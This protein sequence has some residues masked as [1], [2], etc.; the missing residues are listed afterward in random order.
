MTD[1]SDLSHLP[2]YR[3]PR[4]SVFSARKIA[5]M[6]SV[7]AGLGASVYGFS[8]STSPGDLFSSPAHAQVNQEVRKVER[9]IG[10][11]DIVERVKPSVISVKV[12][13][14][15]KT[16]SNDDGDDSSSPFQPGS[17]M[18]RFFRRFG[19]P[20]GFPGLKGGRGRVVQGQ[21]SGFFISPDG[22]AV[23][24]NH[25]VDGADKVEVTTDDGK[26]YT[27]KVIGTDQR[28]DLALI[29]VEGSSNFP[30]AK[31]ADGKPRI[32]DWVLAVGNPFGLGGTV[33]AGIVSASGRDIGNG[34]YDDFIQI[35]APV[36]KG[37]SGGPAFNTEGEVMGVNTAIYSPSGGSVGIAF[38]IP[39]NTVKSV[40]AQ[41]KDK[42]SVSRGWIGVQIQPV[43]SDIA[44]SLGMKKA[45]GAL[46]AEP[47][48]NG[49]A[50]KAG[51]ESGDVITA[52]N[53]EPVKDARELAR[54]I[55]GMAPGASVKL[56][57]LH[58]GQDKVVN[59][60]LGQLP[61]TV[62]AK[63]DTDNDSGKGASRGT[64]V[65]KLGM[66]VAPANSVAGAGKE[67]V[68]V[69]EVDPKSAAAERGFK[70]GDVILEVG[71]KSVSTAAEVRDAINT[72]R[73]DNKNSV[74]M[75]VKSGGQS[76]FVAVPIAKG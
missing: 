61:N 51:I 43:T 23:T 74:L 48:A 33:T 65:P 53:G 2:S 41:L 59:L 72:A 73:T 12:N 36:N 14:K 17:P 57:V 22:Y 49:P 4:R 76:R 66:T 55:G 18:E 58:K 67:G 32:G 64:D 45:E 71:G 63:A 1:R 15:E 75:R 42:G 44:D 62:E 60:T 20:D 13:M 56:N 31:L 9:P 27:A 69:T 46:V 16:A 29:K 30:F 7:V 21:G 11:A 19:G 40:V 5:L 50:A 24:N 26:T 34:P 39:A 8:P 28:T 6:A 68:V 3:Q 35:D 38:S 70:E 25:V 10:F 47:Q 54:T 52:V 37:N